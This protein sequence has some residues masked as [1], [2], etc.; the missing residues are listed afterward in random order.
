MV[1]TFKLRFKKLDVLINN[2]GV[3]LP[4]RR[5]TEDG[6]EES[7]Q[8]NHLSHFI[9]SIMMLDELNKSDDPRIII[10]LPEI[11]TTG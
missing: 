11:R 8:I 1:E 6:L 9:L 2:A 7:F 5:I 4:E 3:C 10:I